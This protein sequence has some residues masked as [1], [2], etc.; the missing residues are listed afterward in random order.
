MEIILYI[1]IAAIVYLTVLLIYPIIPFILLF[2]FLY[3]AVKEQ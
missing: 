3:K 2:T 1:L